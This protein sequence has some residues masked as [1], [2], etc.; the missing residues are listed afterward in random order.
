MVSE[1]IKSKVRESLMIDETRPDYCP[2]CNDVT[3]MSFCQG[4]GFNFLECNV[5]KTTHDY[6]FDHE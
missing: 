5:C 2:H 4:N 6:G 1:V 3:S